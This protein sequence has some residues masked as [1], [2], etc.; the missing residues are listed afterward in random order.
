[1]FKKGLISFLVLFSFQFIVFG[2]SVYHHVSN[3]GIYDFVDELANLKIIDINSVVK[4]YTRQ[5]IADALMIADEHRNELNKRQ[6]QELDFYLRDFG[7]EI[8]P[9]KRDFKKKT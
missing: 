4:P 1:M 7:K 5:F 2:Q 9:T 6:I 3:A 8:Y